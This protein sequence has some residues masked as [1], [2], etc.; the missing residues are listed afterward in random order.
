MRKN[1]NDAQWRVGIDTGGTFVD[2]VVSPPGSS[3]V[4]STKL[5][6][7]AGPDRVAEAV[8]DLGVSG[9]ALVVHGTTRV[10]NAVLESDFSRT[11]LVTTSG[12][13]DV[14]RIGRQ[15]RDHLYDL[16]APARPTPVVPAELTFEIGGRLAPDGSEIEPLDLAAL[17]RLDSWLAHNEIEA[18]AVCLLHAYANPAHER[19]VADALPDAL[20]VSLSHEVAPEIREY[21]RASATVLNAA[22]QAGTQ[23]YLDGVDA[24]LRRLLPDSR[25]FVVHS[26]GSML[27]AATVARSPLATVMS[28]PAAG[29]AAVGKLARRRGVEEAITFDMGGTS[30]D[31]SLIVGG[32]I[33]IARE[34]KVAGHA[35]RVPAVAVDS[36]AVGGGSIIAR[37][38]V[39]AL[40]VGP[41][42]AGSDPGP[43]C[44]GRG[45]TRPTVTDAALLCGLIGAGGDAPGLPLHRDLAEG[46][47]A[48]AGAELGLGAEELAW[49]ALDVAQS[50]MERAL[51]TVVSR[52]GYDLA[53]CTLVA[54]GG[55]G[56]I[57]AGP[58][59][60]RA[61]IRRVL[62]PR[63]APVLSAVG[64]C[65]ADA[66][67]EAVRGFRAELD[68]DGLARAEGVLGE[69]EAAEL[70]RL[71]DH[72]SATVTVGRRLELRYRNQNAELAVE[73]DEGADLGSI[74]DSF[75]RAHDAAYGFS[76]PDPVEIT[77][78]CAHLG[79]AA[80]LPWPRPE[81]AAGGPPG[82]SDIDL[83]MPGGEHRRVPVVALTDL[84]AGR[85]VE[86][87]AILVAEFGSITVWTDQVASVDQDQNVLLVA[88]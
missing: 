24:A 39:G 47:L 11:A 20:A 53:G 62:V 69:I 85:A 25:L 79:F 5:P 59:A 14:L 44:Y 82:R 57:H 21:E 18:V 88:G 2:L 42:S 19:A 15:A 37:D 36:I 61:G 6:R 84:A 41:R 48:A 33:E 66:G 54:F 80:A 67:L 4:R 46:A 83:V 16:G 9:E 12:F 3:A 45:G 22:V 10:T 75:E 38:D 65:V 28:G 55:G 63:L 74:R 76:T 60:A 23:A 71:G 26:A 72:G 1:G 64:C 50:L 13:G 49:R 77:A 31:V 73:W 43:A 32:E 86:G 70:G 81:A 52:R 68:A 7:D 58:L 56:P 35:V 8:V 40:V 17:P 34:R 27:P 51:R 29:V 87:P 78:V 30:T